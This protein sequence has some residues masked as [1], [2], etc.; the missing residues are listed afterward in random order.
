MFAAIPL[1][2]AGAVAL[3]GAVAGATLTKKVMQRMDKRKS[4]SPRPLKKSKHSGHSKHR[5]ESDTESA[6]DVDSLY[7]DDDTWS[8]RR[9]TEVRDET[10]SPFQGQNELDD[11]HIVQLLQ[12][13]PVRKSHL[14]DLIE[15]EI[16]HR[17]RRSRWRTVS[18]YDAEGDQPEWVQQN[19][20][21]H[22]EW[23]DD[24]DSDSKEAYLGYLHD[25]LKKARKKS[26]DELEE[27][28]Y[29]RRRGNRRSLYALVERQALNEKMRDERRYLRYG[30]MPP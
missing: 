18:P 21:S 26:L 24:L 12:S 14:T 5:D 11:D 15:P 23:Y 19:Y 2:G 10:R 9:R 25:L 7:S 6:S 1:V 20:R 27:S 28:V 13:L 29:R 8:Q 3:V 4:K 17:S 16:R 30:F 22:R